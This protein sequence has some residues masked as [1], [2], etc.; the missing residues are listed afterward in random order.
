MIVPTEARKDKGVAVITVF[1]D[2][3]NTSV[4]KKFH[5]VVCGRVV[6]SY[7]DTAHIL[8]PND[9]TDSVDQLKNGETEVMCLANWVNDHGHR[10]RCKT[11]YIL[12]RG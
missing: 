4:N 1:L 5:C 11:I 10:D 6:F 9:T 8:V 7:Y 3:K 2:N 12:N